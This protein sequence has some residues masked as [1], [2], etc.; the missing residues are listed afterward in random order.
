MQMAY[1]APS[2]REL[3]ESWPALKRWIDVIAACLL[4]AASAPVIVLASLAIAFVTGGT[5]FLR[6]SA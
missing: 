3:P 2:E 1:S 6:R 4:L 5:P